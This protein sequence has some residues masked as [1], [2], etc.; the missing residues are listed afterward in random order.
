MQSSSDI[1][2]RV[3]E[4][5]DLHTFA[6]SAFAV[7]DL[8]HFEERES[9]NYVDGHYFMHR[10]HELQIKIAEADESNFDDYH[11]WIDVFSTSNNEAAEDIAHK[12][13]RKLSQA[14][15]QAFVPSANWGKASWDGK[16]MRYDT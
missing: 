11:F 9:S 5:V 10:S 3:P 16:G 8:Q 7:F 2:V 14:G 4:N 13:A 12:L 15:W 6:K 1:F